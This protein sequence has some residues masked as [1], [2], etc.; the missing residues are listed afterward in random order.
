MITS[1]AATASIKINHIGTKFS[2]LG[3]VKC[4]TFL[5]LTL[6]KIFAPKFYRNINHQ[7]VLNFSIN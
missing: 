5:E 3:R 2:D 1:N 4:R 7:E 6:S